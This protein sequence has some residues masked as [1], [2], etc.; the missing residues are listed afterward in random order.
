MV[1]EFFWRGPNGAYSTDIM[2]PPETVFM[3]VLTG[4]PPLLLR[5]SKL[6]VTIHGM[7][8]LSGIHPG[9]VAYT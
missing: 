5:G 6:F 1:P 8:Y 3:R 9:I 2:L 7:W 4:F